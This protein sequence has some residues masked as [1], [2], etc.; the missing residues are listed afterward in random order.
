MF[1]SDKGIKVAIIAV[2]AIVA[3]SVA[4]QLMQAGVRAILSYAPITL[5]VPDPVR[6]Q[7][8]DPVLHL[9]RM[10]YYLSE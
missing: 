7:Y 4:D 8:I 6:V 10:T 3:Q 1:L 2:P 5:S 9:Q